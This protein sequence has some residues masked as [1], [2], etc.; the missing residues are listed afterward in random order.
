[1]MQ[2]RGDAVPAPQRQQLQPHEHQ[3]VLRDEEL[4]LRLA[5]ELRRLA[6]EGLDRQRCNKRIIR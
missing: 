6:L 2:L 5:H 4:H 3:Q 1:M